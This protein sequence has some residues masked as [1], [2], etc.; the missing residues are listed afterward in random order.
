VVCDC[1]PGALVIYGVVPILQPANFGRVYA[2]YG[3]VF[4]ILLILWGWPIDQITP[5]RFDIIGAVVALAGVLI[6]YVLAEE[7]MKD[8]ESPFACDTSSSAIVVS[9]GAISLGFSMS[10]PL[11]QRCGTHLVIPSRT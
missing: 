4:I 1:G 8:K 11:V 6:I 7:R 9:G 5:D 10:Y 3:R 2:A